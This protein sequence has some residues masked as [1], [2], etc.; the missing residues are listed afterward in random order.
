MLAGR[1]PYTKAHWHL[2]TA[3]FVSVVTDSLSALWVL[4]LPHLPLGLDFLSVKWGQG[5][6][7]QSSGWN[8]VL[9]LPKAQV[10]PLVRELGSQELHSVANK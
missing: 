7:W 8:F 1:V 10:R 4:V 2:N 6:P 3:G 9:S 5:I